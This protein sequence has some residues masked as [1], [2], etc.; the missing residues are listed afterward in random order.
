MC[1]TR[2]LLKAGLSKGKY[3]VIRTGNRFTSQ[4]AHTVVQTELRGGRMERHRNRVL[5]GGCGGAKNSNTIGQRKNAITLAPE[6]M[7]SWRPKIKSCGISWTTITGS[8][9]ERCF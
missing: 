1:L 7:S 4:T 3:L 6:R 9:C 5:N 2:R 8:S